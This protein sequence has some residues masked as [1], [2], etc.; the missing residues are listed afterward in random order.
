MGPVKKSHFFLLII[1]LHKKENPNGF[2]VIDIQF[3]FNFQEHNVL[4]VPFFRDF[5]KIYANFM[6]KSKV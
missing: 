1:F 2:S 6:L 3:T 5:L 4:I